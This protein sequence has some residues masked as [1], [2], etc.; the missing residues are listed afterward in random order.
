[1]VPTLR[2]P[3]LIRAGPPEGKPASRSFS[4]SCSQRMTNLRLENRDEPRRLV[5]ADVQW[6][7]YE[8][9]ASLL[10]RRST[11]SLVF[12]STEVVRRVRTFPE[13]WR[14]L[15]DADLWAISLTT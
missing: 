12:E 5:I 14:E 10:D 7:V 11:P 9:L 1:M 13:N 15:S 3:T 4:A 6:I 8:L 2:Y